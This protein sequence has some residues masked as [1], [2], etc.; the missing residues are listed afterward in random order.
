MGVID[1][2][3]PP[4]SEPHFIVEESRPFNA[5]IADESTSHEPRQLIFLSG[6]MCYQG[7]H[8]T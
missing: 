1:L 8:R 7:H 6:G 2:E 3:R 4:I 5:L